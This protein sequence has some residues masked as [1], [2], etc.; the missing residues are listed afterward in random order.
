MRTI[1]ASLISW[2]MVVLALLLCYFVVGWEVVV[3]LLEYFIEERRQ[4]GASVGFFEAVAIFVIVMTYMMV[5][6]VIVSAC[7]LT[8]WVAQKM[9]STGGFSWA[10]LLNVFKVEPTT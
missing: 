6:A 5:T 9:H 2:V 10:G 1:F 3:P 8:G 4:S 7:A